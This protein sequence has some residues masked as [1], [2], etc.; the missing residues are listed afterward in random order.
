MSQQKAARTVVVTDPK[1]I[2]AQSAVDIAK[3]VRK[4][5]S[6]V[7]LSKDNQQADGTDVL[8]MLSLLM[9]CG[10]QVVLEATGPD[11]E[12]ALDAI[13]PLFAERETS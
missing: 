13:E 5:H 8:H 9:E 7:T 10:S 6:K 4:F 3:V 12:D 11:A 1:G 2:H